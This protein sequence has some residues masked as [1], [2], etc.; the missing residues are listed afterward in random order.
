MLDR[1]L[2]LRSFV[3]SRNLHFTR[4]Y[5]SISSRCRSCTHTLSCTSNGQAISIFQSLL[6]PKIISTYLCFEASPSHIALWSHA[7]R[8]QS[9]TVVQFYA[10]R[11]AIILY[12]HQPLSWNKLKPVFQ[13]MYRQWHVLL[14]FLVVYL[15][16]LCEKTG[17]LVWLQFVS[18]LCD[19]VCE[20]FSSCH[21][22]FISWFYT[23]LSPFCIHQL[24][25]PWT[26]FL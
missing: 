4:S 2:R 3:W 12:W 21:D 1:L 8:S 15:F 22:Y 9:F 13:K 25:F 6:E 11:M 10:A 23:L 14:H 20:E 19:L 26:H 18:G 7:H 17:I 5:L 16:V 24:L